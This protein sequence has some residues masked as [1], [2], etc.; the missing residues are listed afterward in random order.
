MKARTVQ[1]CRKAIQ[2]LK[3]GSAWPIF[4]KRIL[5]PVRVALHTIST[6]LAMVCWECTNDSRR[7]DLSAMQQVQSQQPVTGGFMN[8]HNHDSVAGMMLPQY[9]NHYSGFAYGTAPNGN[10]FATPYQNQ[11]AMNLGHYSQ[12]QMM[13]PMP[14]ANPYAA[15]GYSGLGIGYQNPMAA[16]MLQMQSLGQELNPR[17][18]DM[19]ERWRQ[20]VMQ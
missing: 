6:K 2:H 5:L 8:G 1:R 10:N 18:M 3:Q 19:V 16:S 14:F 15:M 13:L 11:S 17:Q 9:Q 4:F 12:Q 7:K 20:S